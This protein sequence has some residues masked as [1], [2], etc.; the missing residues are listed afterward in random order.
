MLTG[1]IIRGLFFVCRCNGTERT[2]EEC[3]SKTTG[4]IAEGCGHQGDVGVVC[5]RPIMCDIDDDDK[6]N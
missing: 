4:R 2:L 5:N 6:V 1:S 3:T